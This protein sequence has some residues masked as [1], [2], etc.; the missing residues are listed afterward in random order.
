M[1]GVGIEPRAHEDALVRDYH[2]GLEAAGV[3][4]YD[5]EQCWT[6]YRRGTFAGLLMAVAAS[7]LV[8]RTE[9][10][11]EM[12]LTM[13]ARHSAHARDLDAAELLAG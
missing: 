4:G 2:R 5:W 1:L 11:D 13:A 8:E 3:T 6:D 7:M 9:R 12:F 10:G